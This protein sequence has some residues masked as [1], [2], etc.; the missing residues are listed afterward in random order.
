PRQ[1]LANNFV[2]LRLLTGRISRNR[3]CRSSLCQLPVA[4]AAICRPVHYAVMF[5][6]ARVTAPTP[7]QRR[8]ADEHLARRRSGFAHR[9]PRGLYTGASTRA[10]IAEQRARARL[11][12]FNLLPIGF[13]LL[14][15]N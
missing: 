8:C 3:Q 9:I 10:L 5:G 1:W 12:N 7:L 15:K 11:L 14:R 2:I 13:Q 6:F 4:Q